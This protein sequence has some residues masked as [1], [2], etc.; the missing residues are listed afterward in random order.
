MNTC[1]SSIINLVDNSDEDQTNEILNLCILLKGMTS[2]EKVDFYSYMT[3]NE[4]IEIKVLMIEKI[5][6][7]YKYFLLRVK[8]DQEE[9]KKNEEI[10]DSYIKNNTDLGKFSS[11]GL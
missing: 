7:L 8:Q 2:D 11:S 10:I 1:S 3:R 6:E 5:E 4:D 9:L